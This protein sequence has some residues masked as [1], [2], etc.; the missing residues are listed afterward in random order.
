MLA[1]QS[2]ELGPN[3]RADVDLRLTLGNCVVSIPRSELELPAQHIRQLVN[4]QAPAP[5]IEECPRAAYS[6]LT[7]VE[8]LS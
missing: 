5:E 1:R 3:P 4:L 2:Y 7:P 6:A 8:A